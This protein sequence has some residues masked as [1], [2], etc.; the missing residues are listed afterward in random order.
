MKYCCSIFVFLLLYSGAFSQSLPTDPE[1]NKNTY[2]E[3]ITLDSLTK[4]E[5]F[6]RAKKWIATKAVNNKPDVANLENGD[7]EGDIS[8]IIKLTYD[9]KYKKDANVT[10]HATINEKDEK[11]RYIFTDF[12]IYD[13]KSG[14]KSE[15]SLEAYY[16]KLRHNSKPEFVNQV[17]GETKAL[18]EDLKKMMEKGEVEKED[19][20]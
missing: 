8:F 6:N 15:E 20:W 10:F 1:T 11:Y 12:K 4:E 14:P 19:D 2:K 7:V 9:Y 17:D 18:V 3:T 16:S 13:V 5:L